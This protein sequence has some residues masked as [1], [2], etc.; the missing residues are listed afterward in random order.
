MGGQ[1]RPF[2]RYL[3][4]FIFVSIFL[5]A[6]YAGFLT[7]SAGTLIGTLVIV[8]VLWFGA[9]YWRLSAS[10]ANLDAFGKIL[11]SKVQRPFL[12]LPFCFVVE[13]RWRERTVRVKYVTSILHAAEPWN[14]GISMEP[15]TM[16]DPNL[17]H[18]LTTELTTLSG[19]RVYYEAPET[20]PLSRT[21]FDMRRF[22]DEEVHSVLNELARATEI[23]E[24]GEGL[25]FPCPSCQTT[26]QK[27]E[28]R[29]SQCGWTWETTG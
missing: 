14:I 10:L 5:V 1:D 15:K 6:Y 8:L 24:R 12:G 23:I 22:S 27:D 3:F 26:I 16:A 7:S 2:L 18:W 9:A 13:G 28:A 11:H 19:R 4:A 21:Q 29:C 20:H 17:S 25:E